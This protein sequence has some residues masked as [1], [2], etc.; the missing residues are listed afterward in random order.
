VAAK[1]PETSPFCKG[2]LKNEKEESITLYPPFSKREQE[3]FYQTMLYYN[4]NLKDR[5]RTLRKNMTDAERLLWSRIRRK[6]L[7]GYQ[8]YRQKIIGNYI[9]D[10]YCPKAKLIIELDGSQHYEERGM[11]IDKRR[12]AYLKNFGLKVFRFSDK[13]VFKNLNGVLEKILEDL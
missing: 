9:V 4:K 6:Q 12:D 8:F 10:F 1:S 2:G 3:R 11:K 13:D 7:K 5:S